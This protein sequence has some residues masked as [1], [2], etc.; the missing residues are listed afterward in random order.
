MLGSDYFVLNLDHPKYFPGSN[1]LTLHFGA[2]DAVKIES[3]DI[4]KTKT[5]LMNQLQKAFPNEIPEP[6]KIHVTNWTH[7]P[8]SYGSYSA[9]PIGFTSRMWKELKKTIEIVDK[10]IL[11]G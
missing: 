11:I 9:L 10:N 2:D 4:K 5:E 6:I 8:L 3:Q 7:N 1:I